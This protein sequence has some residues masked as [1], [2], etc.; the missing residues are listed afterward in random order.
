[1]GL[2]FGGEGTSTADH[3]AAVIAVLRAFRG[4]CPFSVDT[5]SN[6]KRYNGAIFS[7]REAC[8]D[9]SRSSQ[10]YGTPPQIPILGRPNAPE[11]PECCDCCGAAGQ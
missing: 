11:C 5:G 3:S 6:L 10:H 2:G 7:I 1:M 8:G 9:G 4:I